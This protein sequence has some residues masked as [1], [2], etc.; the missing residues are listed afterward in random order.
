MA[1]FHFLNKTQPPQVTKLNLPENTSCVL[2]KKRNI[3]V[4]P[5][6][7][8]ILQPD[9]VLVKV[10]TCLLIPSRIC[11]SDLHNYLAGGVG[12]RPVTEP[13]VM[14]HESSGEVI[15]VGDLVK[16]HKVGD[17]VAIEPGLPC[18][19]CINCKEGKVNI[20][21]NMHYCGAPGSVGSLSRYFALP[22]DMAPHIPDHL[23]WEEAGCIQPLARNS[24]ECGCGPIGL[25][26]AAVAH[27]YSARKII[28]FDNN[29]QRVEFAKKYISPLTGKPIIDHVFL[30]K[31]LPT[32]SLKD[33]HASGNGNMTNGQTEALAHALGETGSGAGMGD[34]EMVDED[35]EQTIGDKKWEWAKKIV[36]G[37]VQEAGLAAEEGVDRVV[38]AT[39]AEDCM[40][41]G[42]AIAKQGGN[43]LA[44]GLGHI[45]TNCFPTLAVTNKE[46]NVMGITRYTASCFPS[47]LDLLSRGVVD[48]KQLITKTF[49]LTQSTEAFEAVAA[50]QDMKV[51]IKNQEGFDN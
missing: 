23:S 50:G 44:V 15:A 6:P 31:D 25:I 4:K 40:L 5:K 14:G 37:F 45:Q 46:I 13:I 7:M 8:P 22:A 39:G 28:A 32:S 43:Y 9:G 48:V 11:G 24:F 49:P 51:I 36:A 41:M 21:L 20:C 1:E 26:S 12:G 27:A 18:R 35:H 42:I 3:V 2:L 47:A 10:L 19:R 29:P 34:G 16:T 33:S 38:E 17:R 30:V